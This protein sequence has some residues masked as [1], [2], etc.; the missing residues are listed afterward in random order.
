MSLR[1]IF[2][3]IFFT[4]FGI[5]SQKEVK[6]LGVLPEVIS[7]T[8]GL[9]FYKSKLISHNDSG[10]NAR[11]FEIDTLS[12]EIT[13][14]VTVMNADNMDWEDITQDDA[15][16]YIGDF[17]NNNGNRRDL[18]IYRIAKSDYDQFD[19]VLADRIDFSYEDQSSFV[20]N[21]NSDWDAEALFNFGNTLVVLTKQWGS[22]G[23]VAYVVP[24][25]PGDYRAKKLDRY[26]V[27]GLITGSTYNSTAKL[28]YLTGYS[29]TLTPFIVR[30]EGASDN[31]IFGGKIEKSNL[32]I[33]L[34]QLEGIC[35]VAG[36][37]YFL[38]SELFK[39]D[40]LSISLEAGLFSFESGDEK[41]EDSEEPPMVDPKTLPEDKKEKLIVYQ[42]FGSNTVN[43]K[44]TTQSSIF[45]QA[46]FDSA[47]KR[48]HYMLGAELEGNA[49]D[50]STLK[51]SIYYL[52]F[53]LSDKIMFT[54]FIKY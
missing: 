34:A 32:S 15:Y 5:Y 4:P 38:S 37:T 20:E 36:D 6:T 24:K 23:T 27:N 17:G 43:Y 10:N 35:H 9:I 13:R 52:A 11:L 54:P 42:A 2:I 45:G 41:E 16:I 19:E 39:R 48:V 53:Y 47:G 12:L 7:E 1:L 18:V 30:V 22:N 25:L 50:V 21:S 40:N 8:S 14:T 29:S 46:I 33:N 51:P 49:L 31:A 26:Q 28:L 3:C 44:L